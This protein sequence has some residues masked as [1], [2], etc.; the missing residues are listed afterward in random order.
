VTGRDESRKVI[1]LLGG[2]RSG[3][4]CLD[5]FVI[6]LYLQQMIAPKY[7][8]TFMNPKSFAVAALP[9]LSLLAVAAPANAEVNLLTGE[10][11]SLGNILFPSINFQSSVGS[12]ST[13]P[14]ELLSGHHDPDRH[15]Y[16]VQALELSLGAQLGERFQLFGTYALKPDTDDRWEG[17]FEE[18]YATLSGLPLNSTL[19]GG[20]FLAKFGMHNQNHPHAFTMVDQ[21]IAS[22]RILGE[23]G[24]TLEGAEISLPVLRFLP[25]GWEDRLTIAAGRVAKLHD[26]DHDHAEEEAEFESDGGSLR[27]WTIAGDY[28]LTFAATSQ[29]QHSGGFSGAWG[30]NVFGRRSQIYGVNYD[31]LWRADG[32]LN[33]KGHRETSEFFQWRTELFLRHAEAIASVHGHEEDEHEEE[34]GRHEEEHEHEHEDEHSEEHGEHA[35]EAGG[36]RPERRDF[37]D[38][39]A[40]SVL[41]YGLPGG[42]WQAHLRG[43]YAS[44]NSEAGV[45]ERWRVSPAVTWTP[46]E[47]LPL[48]WKLQYNYDHSPSFGDEHS[49]WL[50]LNFNWGTGCAHAH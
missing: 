34:S 11:V 47:S 33:R 37:T 20:R 45:P 6:V 16:N 48:N 24:L 7:L 41:T 29:T 12:S 28:G 36:G 49:V 44:G 10:G 21:H 13:N 38:F 19:R 25:T 15:G 39:A 18:Y 5:R 32:V 4:V 26:H 30:R 46:S 8:C 2:F 3:M 27:G 17:V 23:D 9:I 43:E 40:Y 22:G 1:S 31:F 50:Q 42:K 35:D 14:G